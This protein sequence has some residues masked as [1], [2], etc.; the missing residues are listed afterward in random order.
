MILE[1]ANP[2]KKLKLITKGFSVGK[3]ATTA[4]YIIDASKA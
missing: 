2:T 3:W 4:R 1:L